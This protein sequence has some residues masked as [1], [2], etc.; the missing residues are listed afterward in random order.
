MFV[1]LRGNL[2]DNEEVKDVIHG[3][4]FKTNA[5]WADLVVVLLSLFNPWKHLLD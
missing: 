4:Y 1:T 5:C 3:D 2:S